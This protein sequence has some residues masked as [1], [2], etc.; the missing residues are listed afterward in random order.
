MFKCQI[1]RALN[2]FEWLAPN[3]SSSS[4][5]SEN[6]GSTFVYCTANY[7]ENCQ[8]SQSVDPELGPLPCDSSEDGS[9]NPKFAAPPMFAKNFFERTVMMQVADVM[10]HELTPS[11]AGTDQVKPTENDDLSFLGGIKHV[12]CVERFSLMRLLFMWL[13]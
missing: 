7:R 12:L 4:F 3:R 10:F 8:R 13:S 5:S 1:Y 6:S 2:L 11:H 9:R